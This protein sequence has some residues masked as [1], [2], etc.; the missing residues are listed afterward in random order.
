MKVTGLPFAVV[1][2]VLSIAHRLRRDAHALQ[3]RR[4][5]G[6]PLG[7]HRRRRRDLLLHRLTRLLGVL[8]RVDR[9]ARS[10][11]RCCWLLRAGST[12]G[13]PLALLVLS[14]SRNVVI[15]M[16][17]VIIAHAVV[18][19]R[20]G[21]EGEHPVR[22]RVAMGALA[23]YAG[24]PDLPLADDRHDRDRH[25]Q[26]V[27][28]HDA[29]LEH[30]DEDQALPVVEPALRLLGRHRTGRGRARHRGVHV[31]HADEALVALGPGDLGLGRRLPGLHHP[32]DEHDAEPGPL[33]PAGLPDDARS[34]RGSSSCAG[35]DATA[36]GL[37]GL[38]VVVGAAQMWWWTEHYL[39]I[40]NL[41]DD[42][43]P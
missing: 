25:A 16:V 23:A 32:R 41:T 26:R 43:Y 30:R 19:W 29:R 13:S 35:G 11:S 3:A 40:E 42:L 36:T 22:F 28:R 34:S 10:S 5:G 20:Q 24:C 15:A 37:L 12:G 4:P 18:R 9:P 6:R 17:P 31:V 38:I 2:P 7:G 14:L 27:Q 39:V 8:H 33:R 21:D 1:A